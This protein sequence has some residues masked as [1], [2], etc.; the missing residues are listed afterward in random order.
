MEAWWSEATDLEFAS[1]NG[2]AYSGGPFRGVIHTTELMDFKPSKRNYFGKFD[3]P[4]FTL[5]MEKG[6]P[7]FYQHFPI[8][9]AARS[10]EN[11]PGGVET[12]RRSA[13]QIELVWKA[14]EID[15][16]PQAMV[17]RLWDWMRWVETQAGVNGSNYAEFKGIEAKGLTGAARMTGDEWNAFDGWCGHQHVPENVHWDP[18]KLDIGRLV[19]ITRPGTPPRCEVA[20]WFGTNAI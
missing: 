17:E 8:T 20:G 6:E 2:G 18:G 16:L 13:I 19:R 1:Q 4:H 9:V 10:L 5:V 15:K 14:A 12:N 3:P 11:P 7:R